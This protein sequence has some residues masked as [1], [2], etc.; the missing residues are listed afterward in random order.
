[1]GY[2]TQLG[3][4]VQL[5][6]RLAQDREELVQLSRLQALKK[7]AVINAKQRHV[8][9]VMEI[10]RL[11]GDVKKRE[12][13]NRMTR[14][15][16]ARKE[17]LDHV[18]QARIYRHFNK[19]DKER[20]PTRIAKF[21]KSAQRNEAGAVDAIARRSVPYPDVSANNSVSDDLSVPPDR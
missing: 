11:K 17:N 5:Y 8:H 15:D 10:K 9:E 7:D 1:M 20:D 16:T 13:V 3:Q 14:F 18:M 6:E 21:I 2:Q 12:Y 19:F 4:E